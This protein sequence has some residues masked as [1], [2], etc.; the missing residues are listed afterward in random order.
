MDG[1]QA[2]IIIR[3]VIHLGHTGDSSRVLSITYLCMYVCTYVCVYVYV[4]MCVCIYTYDLFQFRLI[5]D[6]CLFYCPRVHQCIVTKEFESGPY[7]GR[8]EVGEG[9][10]GGWG[11][12]VEGRGKLGRGGGV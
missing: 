9:R 1:V 8:G 7:G 6:R 5:K 10:G 11:G 4:C 2:I 12:R 3:N